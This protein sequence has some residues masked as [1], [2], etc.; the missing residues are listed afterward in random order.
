MRHFLLDATATRRLLATVAAAFT[1]AVLVW[2]GPARSAQL[3]VIDSNMPNVVMPGEVL[4]DSAVLLP[5]DAVIEVVDMAGDVYTLEGPIDGPFEKPA[6]GEDTTAKGD[7][8]EG[9]IEA[10]PATS[11]FKVG[12]EAEPTREPAT[13]DA[14]D[15]AEDD[16]TD[17]AEIEPEPGEGSGGMISVS[18]DMLS[19]LSD[20]TTEGSRLES[21]T[22]ATPEAAEP[23]GS[24]ATVT[25]EDMEGGT[26]AALDHAAQASAGGAAE[27]EPSPQSAAEKS[28]VAAKSGA[29]TALGFPFFR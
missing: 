10:K 5:E 9:S 3:V 13:D 16:A 22:S 29:A 1:A 12:V 20:A 26:E 25:L 23:P 27:T 21:A 6:P 7:E 4:D 11:F 18:D 24:E 15:G 28:K 14:E 8:S 2:A 19:A 17:S